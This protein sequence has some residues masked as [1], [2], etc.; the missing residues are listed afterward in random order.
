[1]NLRDRL[2]LLKA[3]GK[4]R[5][6]SPVRPA[7]PNT[8]VPRPPAGA[9]AGNHLSGEPT[10]PEPTAPRPAVV[11][12]AL[13]GFLIPTSCG[14]AFYV[15]TRYPVGYS[16]G[17]LPLQTL[18]TIP[19]EAWALI[20][21]LPPETD[22]RR[23]VFLD[24]E[25]TGLAG[26]SGT[27]AFL[28]GLGFFEGDQFVVRQYF[29]RDY[30]EEEALLEAVEQ[31]LAR[32][33]LLVTFNGKTFDWPLLQTRYRMM[34]RRPPLS[35]VPHLDLL[36]PARRIFRARLSQCNLTNLEAQV[37]GIVRQGDVPGH[38]IPPLYFDYLR[39]GDA[40]PLQDVVLHNRLDI[41][42]LVSLGA[43]LGRMAADPLSPT[44]DGE[45]ICGD[46]LFALGRLFADRGLT[47][48]A[49]ACYEAALQRGVEAVSETLVQREL[50]RAYKRLREHERALAIWQEMAE[51]AGGLSLFPYIEMAKYYEHIARDYRQA[52]EV[53][54]RALEIAERRRSLTGGHGPR[55]LQDWQEV[56][57]RL[58][59]LERKLA[60]QGE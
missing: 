17:P 45:L 43:W 24:T 35:G 50:S 41:V 1:M 32:F 60:R 4:S 34:R 19:G 22:M 47:D 52:R 7:S 25:T 11:G 53:A 38:L 36:H 16:R 21:R 10:G 58:S 40:R 37:L 39:T 18:F 3:A 56:Q 59:R 14:E 49:V 13:E 30:P 12:G 26:G 46:D 29:L 15:E 9:P 44:P 5:A 54:L 57:H 8:A 28:V 2:R 42:S 48:R 51:G 20:G 55:T 23:A 27:Y 31:D 33:A 6:A